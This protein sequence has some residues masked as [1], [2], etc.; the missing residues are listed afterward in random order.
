MPITFKVTLCCTCPFSVHDDS[1]RDRDY[2][3]ALT[4]YSAGGF[5]VPPEE[6]PWRHDGVEFEFDEEEANRRYNTWVASQR[7][8]YHR[9]LMK[10]R[11][12]AEADG[13]EQ[14]VL[15]IDK[16]LEGYVKELKELEEKRAGNQGAA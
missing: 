15:D 9:T 5:Q 13:Q 7:R 3:K 6:C 16:Q 10:L 1:S 8:D 14:L 4:G 12:E 2:C 11:A